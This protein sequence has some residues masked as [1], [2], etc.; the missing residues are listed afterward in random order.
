MV[1]IILEKDG[2]GE[3]INLLPSLSPLFLLSTSLARMSLTFATL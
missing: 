2:C 3:G 1:Q